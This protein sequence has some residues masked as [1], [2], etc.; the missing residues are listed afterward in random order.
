MVWDR[1][2]AEDATQEILIKV[3]TN[4]AGFEGRSS[5]KTWVHRIS[6]NHLLDRRRSQ[7]E[8]LSFD[9][10]AADLLD[11]LADERPTDQPELEV[12]ANEV[13]VT[14]TGAMLLCLDRP[15][16]VAY[17]LGEILGLSGPVGASVVG[18]DDATFRKRLQRSRAVLR[19]FMGQHCGLVSADA[20]CHCTRR[21]PRALQLGRITQ[22]LNSRSKAMAAVA[23]IDAL[24]N[25]EHVMQSSSRHRA[26]DAIVKS[27]RSALDGSPTLN[28][29]P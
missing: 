27:W 22:D 14:C 21:V 1:S 2:E 20:A 26:P 19:K 16:R 23:E 9:A 11:G 5:I 24:H 17:V 4:L 12:L 18:I 6:V 8:E 3:V 13:M 28:E 10:L 25:V 15:H 7:H 29:Y